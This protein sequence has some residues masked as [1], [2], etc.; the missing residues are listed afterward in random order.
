VTYEELAGILNCSVMEARQRASLER[1]D[2]KVSRDGK[3]RSKL[4]PPMIGIFI[5]HLKTIDV[6][7][8]GVVDDLRQIHRTAPF[9]RLVT[10]FTK[11]LNGAVDV[12]SG[13]SGTEFSIT[14]PLSQ[15]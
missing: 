6:V 2:R 5:E 13:I 12:R 9:M 1:L 4:S 7:T 15:T 8:D 14:F 11:Q 10:S 3:R